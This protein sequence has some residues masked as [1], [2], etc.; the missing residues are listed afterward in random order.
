M[1]E[2]HHYFESTYAKTMTLKQI[3]ERDKM[4]MQQAQEKGITLICVPFWWDFFSRKVRKETKK[5][6]MHGKR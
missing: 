2:Q 4:K 1:K 6:G 5:K 3:K